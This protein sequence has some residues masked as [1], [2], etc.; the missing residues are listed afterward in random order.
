MRTRLDEIMESFFGT[1]EKPVCYADGARAAVRAA[2][3]RAFQHG[4][5]RRSEENGVSFITR[6]YRSNDEVQ[7]A[8]AEEKVNEGP[9]AFTRYDCVPAGLICWD[10][11]KGERRKGLEYRNAVN[12]SVIWRDQR[13]AGSGCPHIYAFDRRS[14]TDRRKK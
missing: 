14:G 10:E 8:P 7:P 1:D 5:E 12:N 4:V 13:P 11:R 6:H 2:L 3:E 9:K